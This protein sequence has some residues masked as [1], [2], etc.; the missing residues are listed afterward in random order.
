MHIAAATKQ[1]VEWPFDSHWFCSRGLTY[2]EV[3]LNYWSVQ[4]YKV[5]ISMQKNG[6]RF[7]AEKNSYF[8]NHWRC[9][10]AAGSRLEVRHLPSYLH[11]RRSVWLQS[12][13][14]ILPT[15]RG[16]CRLWVTSRKKFLWKLARHWPSRLSYLDAISAAFKVVITTK[17]NPEDFEEYLFGNSPRTIVHH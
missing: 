10:E 12:S 6:N 5:H 3:S 17:F 9:Q 13:M 11:D 8:W 14:T 7:I 15:T 2:L 4:M 16:V 1:R